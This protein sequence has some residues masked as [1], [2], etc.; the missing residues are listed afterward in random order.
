[1]QAFVELSS[2]KKY[3]LRIKSVIV[4]IQTIPEAMGLEMSLTKKKGK[5]PRTEFLFDLTLKSKAKEGNPAK[6]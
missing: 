5:R 3:A 2:E 4:S 1:M 6:E